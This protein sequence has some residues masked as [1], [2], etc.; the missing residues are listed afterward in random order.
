MTKMKNVTYA[1]AILEAIDE[2]M[3]RDKNVLLIGEDVGILGG[4]FK[5]A[6][7]L[8]EKYGDLRVKDTPLSENSFFGMGLGMAITG[9]R[10]IVELMF[11]DFLFLAADQLLNQIAKIRYMSGGQV[12]V[13]LT[14]RTTMELAGH[15]PL[16]IR[17]AFM[18]FCAM[19]QD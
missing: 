17:R 14:V 16:N 10:P 18:L 15:L 5:T 7:G 9:L 2:E 11:S 6:V 3:A 12:K 19:F 13:P 1:Q 8:F 4:N